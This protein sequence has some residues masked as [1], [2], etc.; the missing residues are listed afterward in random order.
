MKGT[1]GRSREHEEIERRSKGDRKEIERRSHLQQDLTAEE[2]ERLDL[3]RALPERRDTNVAEHLRS[4]AVISG[5]QRSSAGISGH[6][7]SS[8]VISGHHLLGLVV[9]DVAVP[10]VGLDAKVGG[11]LASLGEKAFEDRRQEREA[12]IDL[13]ACTIWIEHTC[14]QRPLEAIRGH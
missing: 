9:L 8:A 6:Q 4:S 10:T 13:I 3:G 12:L 14:D 2:I 5:H 7:R 1:Q 11:L